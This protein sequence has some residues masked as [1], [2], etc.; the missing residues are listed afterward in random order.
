MK[1]AP[2]IVVSGATGF[3]GSHLCRRLVRDGN[4]VIGLKRPASNTSRLSDIHGDFRLCDSYD[5]ALSTCFDKKTTV[6]AVL[7][8]ATSYGR[9]GED[10]QAMFDANV[11]FP[12][13]L[14]SLSADAGASL[15]INVDTTLPA[16]LNEYARS[17]KEFLGI[18]SEMARRRRVRFINVRLEYMYGAGDDEGKFPMRVIRACAANEPTLRMTPGEQKRDF[19]YIDDV[20][21]A[22]ETILASADQSA[23]PFDEFELGSGT[24]ITLREFATIACSVAHS[25]TQL[26]F[27]ALP[28][29]EGELMYSCANVTK[30]NRIGWQCKTSLREGIL[31]TI[32]LENRQ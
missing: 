6:R 18:G 10:K 14:M 28:Y 26:Q 30:L 7:H 2:C 8:T 22:F 19:I 31:K 5:T 29:R 27:G 9:K 15:F 16:E 12:L 13:N 3:L 32:E 1:S 25:T 20:V 4:S 23:T 24:A 11:T 21:D 17:K